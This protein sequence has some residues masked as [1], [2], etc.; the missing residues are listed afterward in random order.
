MK[1]M[2]KLRRVDKN[3]NV[4][5]N[6]CHKGVQGFTL[7]EVM[8]VVVV[9]AILAA[10]IYPNYQDHVRRAAVAQAQQEMQ[11]IA[12]QLERFKSKNLT[13]QNFVLT[14]I[15]T[16]N[17]A[18]DVINTPV[19]GSGAV[20]YKITLKDLSDTS[21]ALNNSASKG[22]G[23]VMIA[24]S[25]NDAKNFNLFMTSEGV[26]CKTKDSVTLSGCTGA[27]IVTW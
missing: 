1:N 13:Y 7:I 26:R 18:V 9:I 4:A 17:P 27:D 23:W 25:V 24:E 6:T 12:N 21:K 2:L 14:D 20:K 15:Y 5:S 8:V 3:S 10:I 19:G 11:N 22:F 16:S